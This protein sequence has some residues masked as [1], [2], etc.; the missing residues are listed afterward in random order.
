MD[1]SVILPVVNERENLAQ[2]IPRLKA[3]LEREALSYEI[4][5]VDGNSTDGTR[6]T[7]LAMG[8]RV[9][10]ERR[11]G[12]AGAMMTGFSEARGDYLLTLDADL[13]HDPDF[14]PRMW[15]ARTRGDIVI[16]SR[17]VRGG[18]SYN[19][20]V[21]GKLSD[22]LNW[23][24]RH[25][26]GI[27]VGDL[28]SGFRLYRR[29]AVGHIEI[30]SRNFEMQEEV[31]AKAWTNGFSIVEIPFTYF[32]RAAGTSHARILKFGID[33]ARCALKLRRLRNSPASADYDERAFYS[34]NPLERRWQRRRH[35]IIV[36]WARG[37]GRVLD[38]GCGSSVIAQSLNNAVA[39]DSNL[40]KLRFLRRYEIALVRG[41]AM[42]LPFRDG[43]FDCLVTART[44][45]RLPRDE[46]LFTEMRR[47]LKPDGTLIVGTLDHS[48]PGWR[49]ARPL[50][51]LLVPDG[52]GQCTTRY[53]RAEIE[54]ILL[55]HGFALQESEY[56][57][58]VELILKCRKVGIG[59]NAAV[60]A[61]TEPCAPPGAA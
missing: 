35:R 17:Y 21:R 55:R 54:E 41:A 25:A 26:L 31:L 18:V 8:A 45:E 49:A 50:Q 28:S 40:A 20:L 33:L 36:G 2:L 13:S 52:F 46:K 22:L 37:A 5:V 43:S 32:P 7:A 16:A 1:V 58:G 47:V 4:V 29:E 59:G 10:P 42:E 61:P 27:P 11:R 44:L 53:T 39:M 30:E 48:A 34:L 9:V 19:S 6:E 51:K 23:T 60:A 24:F 12:Y 3:V 57:A 14:F 56:V 15:R 38:A